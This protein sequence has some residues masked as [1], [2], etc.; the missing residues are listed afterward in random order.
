VSYTAQ[1]VF[2][3]TIKDK[4]DHPNESS[5]PNFSSDFFTISFSY[6]EHIR[7]IAPRL[8]E[9]KGFGNYFHELLVTSLENDGHT[10]ELISEHMPQKRVVYSLENDLID[11]FWLI[12]SAKRNKKHTPVNVGL[13]EGLIGQRVL[14]I[15]KNDQS[16]FD[17]I[18]TLEQFRQLNLTAGLGQGWYDSDVWKLNNLAYKEQDGPWNIIY[19]MLKPGR[20]YDYFPRGMSEIVFESRQHPDLKTEDN[21]ILKYDRNFKFYLSNK[22]SHYQ[23]AIE[24]ALLESQKSGLIGELISK[25][26]SDGFNKLNYNKRII[27]E[28]DTPH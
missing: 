4:S 14:L 23:Q 5:N 13:T 19:K 11:I 20:D 10:V 22:A 9:M 1:V 26:M 15:R 12:E 8:A 24:Q 21:L 27:I 18:T 17:G 7:L 16:L 25:H 3:V 6:A 28:L 2:C